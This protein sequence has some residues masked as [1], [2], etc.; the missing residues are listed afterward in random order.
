MRRRHD[1]SAPSTDNYSDG[2]DGDS[3]FNKEGEAGRSDP[4]TNTTNVDTDVE[5][6]D[7]IDMSWIT[8][9]GEDHPPG[10]YRI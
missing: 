6:G 9:E 4:N 2:S 1:S 7:K 3:C 8:R 10:Y 5:G